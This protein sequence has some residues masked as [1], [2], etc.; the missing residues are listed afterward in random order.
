MALEAVGVFPRRQWI[1]DPLPFLHDQLMD[2]LM[3]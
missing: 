1:M 3:N 2:Q